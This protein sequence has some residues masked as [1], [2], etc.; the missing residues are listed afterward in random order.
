MSA[1]VRSSNVPPGFRLP[2]AAQV[3][4]LMADP[5]GFYE[6]GRRRFGPVFSLRY[7][8]LPPE[9]CVATAELAEEVFATDGGPGRAG[10]MRR[11]FIGPLVGEQSLLCLDGEPWW[12]HRRLVSPPLHGRA[13]AAWRDRIADIAAAEAA[14]WP[15]GTA[16]PVRPAMERITLEVIMR[17]VFGIEDAR[18]LGALRTLLPRLMRLAGSA[19]LVRIPPNARERALSSPLL[20]RAGALPTT[21]YVRARDEVDAILYDE[22]ARR[23]AEPCAE[24][25]DVLSQLVASRDEDGEPLTAREIRDELMTL[26]VAGHETT[27]TALTWTFERLVRTPSAMDALVADIA[28]GTQAARGETSY[29]DA[30]V[31]EGLR[32]RPVVLGAPRLLDETA[33]VG[34]YEIPAGWYLSASV[35][36]VLSDPEAF[37]SPEVFRPERFIVGESS[38]ED[39]ARANR[40]WIP[41]GGGRRYCAGAQLA[42]LEMRVVLAEVLRRVTLMAA[43]PEDEK[44]RLKNVTLAPAKSGLVIAYPRAG[45]AAA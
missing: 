30:V 12:R 7:P 23:R 17:V 32:A 18:R 44:R 13:V 19:A 28:A 11:A 37:P 15:V 10:E 33:K 43:N 36:L 9:V 31:K 41:F 20:L 6:A 38:A 5:L 2:P 26:L 40:S 34:G 45:A 14:R 24:A 1:T 29:L 4:W 35:P 22:I 25:A 21:R 27:A 3:A 16:M 42:L 39:V 8:G